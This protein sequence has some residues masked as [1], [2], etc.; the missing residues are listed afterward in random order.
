MIILAIILVSIGIIFLL[1]SLKPTL[2][3]C[4][5]DN[6]IGWR[7]LLGLICLFLLSY[8]IYFY[9][10]IDHHSHGTNGMVETGLAAILCCGAIF[11]SKVIQLSL[12]TINKTQKIAA[13]QKYNSLHDSLT[14][15]PNRKYFLQKLNDQVKGSQPFSLF[16]ININ[17]FKQINDM[18]GHYYADQVLIEVTELIKLQLNEKC[19]LSRISDTQLPL[20]SCAVSPD[21][22]EKLVSRIHH[23]LMTPLHLNGYDIKINLSFGGSIF[24]TNN[25]NSDTLLQ[26][27]DLALNVAKQKQN[28]YV[29]Y[30]EKLDSD[31]KLRLEISSKL[32]SALEKEEFDVYYQPI[33]KLSKSHIIHLEALI[34][35]P[36]GNNHFIPPDKFIPIAEQNNQIR[37]ITLFVLN[38]ICKHLKELKGAGF[39]ACIHI[40]LSARDLQDDYISKYLAKLL[41]QNLISPEQLI[42]EVTETAVMTDL[43]TTKNILNHLNKQGFLISL[44]DFGTGYS[45]LSML[46]ELPINQI[47]IDRSFVTFMAQEE[48]NHAIVRS[49]IFLAR[50]M[51]CTVVAEGVETKDSVDALIALQCDF[52]QG[53]YYSKPLPLT[54]LI[55]YCKQ[56]KTIKHITTDFQI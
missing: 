39:D 25:T 11:V 48:T 20:L 31:T 8:L 55:S 41:K 16:I 50:S 15:L 9:H 35:W 18:F 14:G 34:R 53:Y 17:G 43:A 22:I 38:K 5:L 56:I 40:N 45:S 27:A 33:H 36:Q 28:E 1:L 7:A 13:E 29:I 21:N 32:N 49:T 44:D 52:L 23:S 19:F 51:N 54:D 3:I 46:Q 47:K 6:T 26:Q 30:D 37:K 24:P 10:L 4:R 42:L 2:I 12:Q